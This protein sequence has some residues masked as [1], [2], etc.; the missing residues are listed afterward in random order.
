MKYSFIFLLSI[1]LFSCKKENAP[2]TTTPAKMEFTFI[3]A[4]TAISINSGNRITNLKSHVLYQKGSAEN[5]TLTA[6]N[7]PTGISFN[8]S[9]PKSYASSLFTLNNSTALTLPDI[10]VANTVPTGTYT[11]TIT[12]T[13]TSGFSSTYTITLNVIQCIEQTENTAQGIYKGNWTF[14]SIIPALA[15]TITILNL[16][17]I[18]DK[19][20]LLQAKSV[21]ALIFVATMNG[22]NFTIENLSLPSLPIGTITLTNVTINGDGSFDCTGKTITLNLK[23]VSGNIS[24]PPLPPISLA[25]QTFSGTFSR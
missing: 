9:L 10:L 3:S 1:V 15:D 24:F 12:A 5:I 19:K 7:L 17:N 16:L 8:P 21:S 23:F 18:P 6:S 20:V 2:T 25:G 14:A 4:D 22:N 13:A 11:I